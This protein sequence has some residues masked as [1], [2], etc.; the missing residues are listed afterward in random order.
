MKKRIVASALALLVAACSSP[1][2]PGSSPMPAAVQRSA[3]MRPAKMKLTGYYNVP[4]F[5][6]V[7]IDGLA[8][9]PGRSIWY[10]EFEGSS[11]GKMTTAGVT[12]ASYTA[13]N[14]AQLE[15]IAVSHSRKRIWTGGYGGTMVMITAGGTQLDFPIAGAHISA[16]ILG[17][18]KNMWFTDYGNDKIGRITANGA[19]TEFA[20]PA[21]SI[22]S[23]MVVGPDGNFW[24]VDEGLN[25]ILK[26]SPSGVTLA[27]YGSATLEVPINIVAA[28][29]G[30]LYFSQAASNTTINDKIARITTKGRI[31]EIET[32]PPNAYPNHLTVGKDKNVYYSIA[33]LQAVGKIDLASGKG[34]YQYLPFTSDIGTDAILSGPDGR[35]YLAGGYTIYAVTL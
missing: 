7:G 13:P 31:T 24:I 26:E 16:V 22:P 23:D 2:S 10:T 5:G 30:N 20:L 33:H 28:P 35:L 18:D 29:D 21:G 15:G 14:E 6:S 32:L 11:I 3:A 8:N 9:G 19:V 1:G 17:P 4:S 25:K 12:T 27:S 34:T